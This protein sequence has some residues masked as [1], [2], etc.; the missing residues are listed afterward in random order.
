MRAWQAE[1]S[2]CA[3][4]ERLPEAE[5]ARLEVALADRLV[6]RSAAERAPGY[7]RAERLSADRVAYAATGD[8]RAGLVALGGEASDAAARERAVLEDPA[9]VDLIGFARALVG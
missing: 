1:L 2:A 5:R 8:L 6:D 4:S 9:L 7:A 3:R